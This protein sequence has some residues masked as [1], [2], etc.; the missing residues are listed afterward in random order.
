M[1]VP[2]IVIDSKIN[3]PLVGTWEKASVKI[4]MKKARLSLSFNKP[5]QKL[6]LKIAGIDAD[7]TST[8]DSK[9]WN[10]VIPDIKQGTYTAHVLANN[11]LVEMPEITILPALGGGDGDLP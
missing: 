11:I 4:M 3:A 1:L 8:D 9:R 6:Q 10:A 5:V 2:V 7:V